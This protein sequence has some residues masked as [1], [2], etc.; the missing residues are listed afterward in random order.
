MDAFEGENMQTQYRVLNYKIDLY[1]LDYKLAIEVNEKGHEDRRIDY[2]IKRQKAIEKEVSCEFIRINPDEK[3]FNVFKVINEIYR[4][5]IK[6]I[7]K[8][9][10]KSTKEYLIDELSKRLLGLEFKKNNSIKSKALKHI[11]KNILLT[12]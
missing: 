10:E 8:L 5:T 2:E 3:F 7:K 12:L 1:F 11:V 4:H 6:S 9:T